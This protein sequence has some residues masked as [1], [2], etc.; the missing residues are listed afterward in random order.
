[1]SPVLLMALIGCTPHDGE[2]KGDFALYL[3]SETSDNLNKLRAYNKDATD[4]KDLVPLDCRPLTGLSDDPEEQEAM[5]AAE[6]LP[7][8]DYN[9]E[10][11]T[12]DSDG[13]SVP[14]APNWFWWLTEYSYY[15]RTGTVEPWRVEA[16]QTTEGDIQILV[17][18]D[19]ADFGDVRFGFTIN[20]D[21]QPTD[22]V[23]D[24]AGG[25]AEEPIDGDWLAAWSAN[26]D[27]YTRYNLNSGTYQINPEALEGDADY[28][29]FDNEWYAGTAF[30][31]YGEE[32]MYNHSTDYQDY[33]GYG[34]TYALIY[35]ES[36]NRLLY[37]PTYS[38][39][40]SGAGTYE[41]LLED[42]SAALN[43]TDADLHAIGK[44]DSSKLQL[45]L[46]VDNNNWREPTDDSV[47]LYNW[48]EVT[49]SWVRIKDGADFTVGKSSSPKIEGD[50]Q[51]QLDGVA[52]A[53]KLF[54]KG[55]FSITN[56]RDDSNLGYAPTLE[57]EKMEENGTPKCG[58]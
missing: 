6:R 29:F 19:D 31:R 37:F 30:G 33:S 34:Y 43:S 35:G 13:N 5:E 44:L 23:D 38:G 2:V 39:E 40:F 36:V 55:E 47:G 51:I 45:D 7:G 42:M 58:Q 17:H 57:E 9:A 24:G 8:V 11:T 41:N 56:I 3:A 53:S 18:M 27:G 49:T 21:F 50:F 48:A 54:V 28:W 15:L 26:E 4:I 32:D 25:S 14:I 52:S 20:P 16:V 22:C 1:M 46:K 10:C 12:T